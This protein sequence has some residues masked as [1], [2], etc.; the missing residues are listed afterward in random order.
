M[1]IVLLI[2]L[3]LTA[4]TPT[5]GVCFIIIVIIFWM[6]LPWWVAVLVVVLVAYNKGK[7]MIT[8]SGGD[9]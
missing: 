5:V 9:E 8:K 6:Q 2:G 7:R 3:I 4:K 1:L